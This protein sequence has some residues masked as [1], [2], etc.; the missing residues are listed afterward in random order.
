MALDK[1]HNVLEPPRGE[2]PYFA[3]GVRGYSTYK[4]LGPL[5][6]NSERSQHISFPSSFILQTFIGHENGH[7]YLQCFIQY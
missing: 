3:V 4:A 1:S 5:L 7:I 6:G 2:C